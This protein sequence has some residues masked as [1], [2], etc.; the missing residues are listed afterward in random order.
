MKKFAM[1]CIA[2][3]L[4]LAIVGC[5]G[6]KKKT[7]QAAPANNAQPKQATVLKVGVAGDVYTNILNQARPALT[8]EG[9]ELQVVPFKEAFNLQNSLDLVEKK[10]DASFYQKKLEFNTAN[11][12]LKLGL[13]ALCTVH[14]DE[15]LAI[16]SAKIKSLKEPSY[17]AIAPVDNMGRTLETLRAAGVLKLKKAAG[18]NNDYDDIVAGSEKAK[19]YYQEGKNIPGS[20]Q[21]FDWA[22]MSPAQAAQAKL[23]L[24]DAIFVEP[25]ESI[26]ASVV[27]VRK[28]EGNKPELKA[29]KKVLTSPEMKQYIETNYKGRVIAAF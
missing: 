10:I 18:L 28:Q 9:V 29:L 26:Y 14:I 6:D 1:T 21:L 27:A 23:T 15:P 11:N 16:Y 13:E 17:K 22:L 20:Y 8:K 3:T 19:I 4:A 25:K 2:C 24:K 7:A 5:G 12:E